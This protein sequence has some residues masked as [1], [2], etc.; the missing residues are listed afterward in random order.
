MIVTR[1]ETLHRLFGDCAIEPSTIHIWAFRIWLSGWPCKFVGCQAAG[2]R[3]GWRLAVVYSCSL[4]RWRGDSGV[5]AVY[6]Q[7]N[8]LAVLL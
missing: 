6:F 4:I 1:L 2:G 5:S 7:V 8:D 3:S